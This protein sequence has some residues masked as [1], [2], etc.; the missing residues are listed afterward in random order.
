MMPH[1][2]GALP[3]EIVA[4]VI[5]ASSSKGL[6][7]RIFAACF[8]TRVQKHEAKILICKPL[9]EEANMTK[10]TI[11]V[12]NAPCSWGI[13]ENVEGERGGYA[14]VLDEMHETGYIGTELGDWGFMPT[15]PRALRRELDRRQLKLLASWVTV[16]LHDP[17]RLGADETDVLRTAR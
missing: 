12:G 13:I 11:S 10:A 17:S 2:Q 14:L 16:H 15:D 9:D 1:E 7:I 6:Q 5:F 8:C 4:F 3:T